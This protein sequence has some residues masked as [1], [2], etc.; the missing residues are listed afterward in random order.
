VLRATGGDDRDVKLGVES[1]LAVPRE[2]AERLLEVLD[3]LA[4]G[5]APSVVPFDI[6]LSTGQ[7]A[8][9]LGVSRQY[10]V[11]LL[12][13]GQLPFRWSGSR[14]RVRLAD[15]L[16]YLRADDR[17]RRARLADVLAGDPFTDPA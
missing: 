10:A 4:D 5:F 8:G 3:A 12:D 1:P 15:A 13:R 11:R 2:A 9:L 14:R 16:A 6:D 17:R 7:L